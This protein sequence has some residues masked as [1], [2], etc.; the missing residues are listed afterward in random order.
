MLYLMTYHLGNFLIAPQ[1]DNLTCF[2]LGFGNQP[3][4]KNRPTSESLRNHHKL[5]LVSS[6]MVFATSCVGTGNNHESFMFAKMTSSNMTHVEPPKR[7]STR[8]HSPPKQSS[9]RGKLLQ[10][11]WCR[12]MQHWLSHCRRIVE[13]RKGGCEDLVIILLVMDVGK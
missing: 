1:T 10:L 3:P 7:S 2:S 6:I 11:Y 12:L 8:P 4:Q 13:T 9:V 5:P